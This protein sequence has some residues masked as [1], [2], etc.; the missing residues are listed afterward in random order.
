MKK[1]LNVKVEVGMI[2]QTSRGSGVVAAISP[3]EFD[4]G[5]LYTVRLNGGELICTQFVSV[6]G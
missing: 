5:N 2:V 6:V 4:F 3:M 1:V